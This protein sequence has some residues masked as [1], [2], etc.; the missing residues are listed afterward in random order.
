ME[1]RSSWLRHRE[2]LGHVP[3]RAGAEEL[4]INKRLLLSIYLSICLSV[5]LS[6]YII[7]Y[8]DR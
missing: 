2:G 3:G 1:A 5:Y 7:T 6:I 8:I 4:F